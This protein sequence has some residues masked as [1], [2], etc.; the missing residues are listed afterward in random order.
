MFCF[1]L[2]WFYI[3]YLISAFMQVFLD[4][5]FTFTQCSVTLYDVCFLVFALILCHCVTFTINK[6]LYQPVVVSV[7]KKHFIVNE[8]WTKCKVTASSKAS[9]HLN[10]LWQEAKNERFWTTASIVAE[11]GTILTRISSFVQPTCAM[12]KHYL[13]RTQLKKMNANIFC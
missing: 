5:H 13:N 1:V 3:Y 4:K 9:L 2:M 10:F 11:A 12:S 7:T 6:T 8:A